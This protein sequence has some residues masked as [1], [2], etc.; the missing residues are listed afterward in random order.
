LFLAVDR[1]RDRNADRHLHVADRQHDVELRDVVVLGVFEIDHTLLDQFLD[2]FRRQSLAREF[3]NDNLIQRHLGYHQVLRCLVAIAV[4]GG[5]RDGV[6]HVAV[7]RQIDRERAPGIRQR[8]LD[9]P[10]G[11]G[12]GH[13]DVGGRLGR[14]NGAYEQEQG[15]QAHRAG[16]RPAPIEQ[17]FHD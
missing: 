3:G 5:D 11:R 9:R 14:R 16:A 12:N 15:R 8:L 10:A 17:R 6:H 1:D 13:A 7:Q 2:F 4:G